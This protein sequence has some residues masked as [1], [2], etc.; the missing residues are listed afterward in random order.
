MRYYYDY[1][2]RL[3]GVIT[4]EQVYEDYKAFKYGR[5]SSEDLSNGHPL[6]RG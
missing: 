2:S 4:L 5:V 6:R 3:R 1:S